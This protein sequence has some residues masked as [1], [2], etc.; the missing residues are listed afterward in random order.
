MK[1]HIIHIV[2]FA[3]PYPPDYGGV[4]DVF[5]KIK[6]LW[7]NDIEVILHCFEYERTRNDELLKYCKEVYYYPRNKSLA[8]FFSFKPF[9][10][11]SR[12][13]S[14][15]LNNLIKDTHPVLLEGI[16][17]SFYLST[18]LK[19]KRKVILRTH[20]IEY[21]YY[22]ALAKKETNFFRWFYYFVESIKLKNYEKQQ[23]IKGCLIAAISP[24][25]YLYFQ[26]L[27]SNTIYLPAF[28]ANKQVLAK[29]G[30]GNF[31][32][33]HGNLSVNENITA[34]G[35][36]LKNICPKVDYPF[37]FAGKNPPQKL[38]DKVKN[39]KNAELIINPSEE[40]MN[41]LIRDAHIHLLITFQDT[42]I[43]L[44]LINALFGGRFCLANTPMVKNT[45]LESLVHIANTPQQFVTEINH[46]MKQS[47]TEDLLNNRKHS[48]LKNVN[49]NLNVQKLIPLLD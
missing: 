28:H 46:L 8:D 42:G 44:K 14:A 27:N 15:L 22:R 37:K 19:N 23:A 39:R 24:N 26:S 7:E 16:H 21:K 11:K 38:I 4:I 12:M 32:L 47:F 41:E 9:I 40:K 33:F 36:I 2:S 3:I 31:I 34:A 25:D 17:S 49:N 45:P 48:L 18:L 1:H 29:P 35:Y 30:T 5:Y 13:S 43:K 6:A 20:N 10:V